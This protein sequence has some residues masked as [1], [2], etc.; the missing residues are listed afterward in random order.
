MP[1]PVVTP[2]ALRGVLR[3][4]NVGVAF[5]PL[6]D[7]RQGTV[8]GYEA[9]AR[10]PE[11]GPASWFATAREAGLEV[12]LNRLACTAAIEH[13]APLA[14]WAPSAL[15]FINASTPTSAI[16]VGD[17]AARSPHAHRIVIEMTEEL[18]AEAQDLVYVVQE[19]RG[20]GL[21]LAIDDMGSGQSDPHRFHLLAPEVM[22]LDRRLV[23]RFLAGQKQAQ[24][25]VA[26][27]VRLAESSGCYVLAEGIER[28]DWLKALSEQGVSLAQ[29]YVLG[30]PSTADNWVGSVLERTAMSGPLGE[31]HGQ[32][33]VPGSIAQIGREWLHHHRDDLIERLVE[34][35]GGLRVDEP[36]YRQIMD[37]IQDGFQPDVWRYGLSPQLV[38]RVGALEAP[39]S[40]IVQTFVWL[41]EIMRDTLLRPAGIPDARELQRMAEIT[42]WLDAVQLAVLRQ[43]QRLTLQAAAFHQEELDRRARQTALLR[44]MLGNLSDGRM[45]EWSPHRAAEIVGAD[46]AAVVLSRPG[47]GQTIFAYPEDGPAVRDATESWLRRTD[48]HTRGAFQRR[49]AGG[50][51]RLHG[52][53][54]SL[55]AAQITFEGERVGVLLA[56]R[57]EAVRFTHRDEEAF[58]LLASQIGAVVHAQARLNDIVR[59]EHELLSIEEVA[60]NLADAA[61]PTQAAD[62]VLTAVQVLLAAER[63][64]LVLGGTGSAKETVI[65]PK[66]GMR[67]AGQDT[68]RAVA[69]RIGDRDEPIFLRDG[70]SSIAAFGDGPLIAEGDR[71]RALAAVPLRLDG[72]TFG[73]LGVASE[74]PYRFEVRSVEVLERMA[75]LFCL[76]YRRVGPQRARA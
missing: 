39:A 76:A 15:L 18:I 58:V 43:R 2:T 31:G 28:E 70:D 9:L 3:R 40:A 49:V 26:E 23:M 44:E 27:Y 38:Q 64:F 71:T 11:H 29:G 14:E 7:L 61:D 63:Y 47:G 34:R 13:F 55:M 45:E 30:R 42:S 62:A 25:R 56:W 68:I 24:R 10:F 8:F 66:G 16:E 51:R 46:G 65:L 60:A 48:G 74:L 32:P 35:A 59:R 20:S 1:N 12:Q 50:I 53:F 67:G 37:I 75:G 72:H 36:L 69:R 5:Q 22:K 54:S 41:R 19:L 57:R 4:R 17:I 73:C 6:W 33:R 21:R 52:P